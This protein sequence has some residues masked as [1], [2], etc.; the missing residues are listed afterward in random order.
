[1]SSRRPAQ[2]GEGPV[3]DGRSK[4]VSARDNGRKRARRRV[5]WRSGLSTKLLVLTA[6]FVMLSEIFIYLP[7]IARYRLGFLNN[8]LSDAHLASL[9]LDAAPDNMVSPE[10]TRKLLSHAKALVIVKRMADA[11]RQ[12]LIA[13]MPPKVSRRVNLGNPMFFPLI[14]D[15][16]DVLLNGGDRVLRIVGPSPRDPAT[17]LEVLISEKPLRDGM[18]KYSQ[19]ILFLSLVISFFTAC[20]VFLTLHW[21]IVRPVKRLTENMVRFSD[22]PTDEA[23]L[24]EPGRRHDEVGLAE[25][26][27]SHMQKNLLTTLRQNERLAA[28]GAAVTRINHDLRNMLASAQL[29]S[30]RLESSKD[31]GVQ[32][33]APT[34]VRSID[35]AVR[36]CTQTLDFAKDSK[37]TQKVEPFM[38]PELAAELAA[39]HGPEYPDVA[40]SADMPGDLTIVA[41]RGQIFR[42]LSNLMRNAAQSGARQI[43]VSARAPDSRVEITVADD[44]PGLPEE[45][46]EALFK[47]FKTRPGTGGTGLGMAIAHEIVSA[48]GGTIELLSSDADGTRFL[49]TLPQ[50]KAALADHAQ[51]LAAAE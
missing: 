20:L 47:P 21:F 6:V 27:Y 3:R 16:I 46:R 39:V 34:L 14:W 7:S 41:D 15:A 44:G 31:P 26:E 4:G 8:V 40:F 18:L 28:L 22:D 30:D 17:A 19:R 45:I 43:T 50:D 23:R 1:M 51:A 24:L 25:H 12:V 42:A 33:I 10:L 5:T 37:A 49:L 13:E 32:R 48:H 38:L 2:A 35:R 36:L 29:V 11:P 9:A